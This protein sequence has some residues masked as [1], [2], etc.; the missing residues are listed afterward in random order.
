M[1]S[2][3]VIL[4]GGGTAG[5]VEPALAVARWLMSADSSISCEF[6]GTKSGLEVRLIPAAGY[7]LHTIRKA[8][9][10]RSI[11]I[12]SLAFPFTFSISVLQALR[13]IRG[14]EIVI[15][16]GGYVSAS[17]YIAARIARKPVVIHEANAIPGWANKLGAKFARRVAIAFEASR[18]TG[19]DWNS[20]IL[21]GMPMRSSIAES[22]SHSSDRSDYLSQFGLNEKLPTV[23]VFGGS[24]GARS[25][26]EAIAQTLAK[27]SDIQIIHSLGKSA[28]LPAATSTYKPVSYIDEMEKAYIA[29]DLIISRSG[30]VSCAEIA[31]VGRY[32]VLVPLPIGNGEQEAN[33]IELTQNG[34]AEICLNRDF[35]AA[36]L[37]INIDRLLAK[38]RDY[39]GT[40]HPSIHAS[41]AKAVGELALDLMNSVGA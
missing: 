33:A 11:N 2:R 20:A 28:D 3:R 18:R 19:G 1:S 27:R 36:W 6:I 39:R 30:A 40:S 8:A 16:F 35:S 26:N 22:Q 38:A 14:A 41:A 31:C 32:A 23:L 24:Q 9:L 37:D 5:H 15:G 7:R 21:T 29:A 34:A 10:P 13:A 12:D 17:S 4:V 25:I